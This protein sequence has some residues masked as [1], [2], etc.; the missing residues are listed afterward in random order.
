MRSELRY[1]LRMLLT[2]G[3][4]AAVVAGA[5]YATGVLGA[6]EDSS[7]DARFRHRPAQQPSDLL[8]VAADDRTFDDLGL[9][10]PFPRSLFGRAAKRCTARARGRS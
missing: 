10:W 7:I 1:R 3:L 2:A 9:Q 8:V 6:L 4:L 5:A